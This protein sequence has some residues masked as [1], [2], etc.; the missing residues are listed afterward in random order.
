VEITKTKKGHF[1]GVTEMTVG[2]DAAQ[3]IRSIAEPFSTMSLQPCGLPVLVPSPC[4]A[5]PA[6]ESTAGYSSATNSM[7]C[8]AN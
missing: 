7:S 3:K 2:K 5:H 4:V 1:S 6:T 8:L